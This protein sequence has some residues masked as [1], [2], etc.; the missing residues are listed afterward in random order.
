MEKFTA[1]LMHPLQSA[2]ADFCVLHEKPSSGFAVNSAGS[3]ALDFWGRFCCWEVGVEAAVAAR[4][5]R[6]GGRCGQEPP[7]DGRQEG[8]WRDP[9]PGA[10]TN[11]FKIKYRGRVTA[12]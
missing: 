8:A 12:A 11:T 2:G 4:R 1:Q 5:G 6:S 7:W 3:A 9:G 10:L